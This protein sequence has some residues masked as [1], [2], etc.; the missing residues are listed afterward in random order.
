[1]ISS[2]DRY[3]ETLGLWPG[4]SLEELRRAYRGLVRVW[5]PDRFNN[6]PELQQRAQEKLKVINESYSKLRANRSTAGTKTHNR[7]PRA[8]SRPVSKEHTAS[9]NEETLG[10][11][12]K[13]ALVIEND[14]EARK[15]LRDFFLR[16]GYRV[17][18]AR[19]GE[20]AIWAYIRGRPEV[21]FMGTRRLDGSGPETIRRLKAINPESTLILA[22]DTAH[23]EADHQP[24]AKEVFY[25]NKPI[26]YNYLQ[27]VMNAEIGLN[28]SI[29]DISI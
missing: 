10:K 6:D 19:P 8:Q 5:H 27:L 24:K 12:Q 18:E 28:G 29:V 23:R 7:K 9:P 21:V 25:V 16:G 4:A 22:S 14:A 20:E 11:K 17:V 13:T 3:Y 15:R 1:M 26:N 2:V